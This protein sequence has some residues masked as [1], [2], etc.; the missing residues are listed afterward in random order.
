M[1]PDNRQSPT[2]ECPTRR[3]AV[4]GVGSR[5]RSDDALG[6]AI[7]ERV[8]SLSLPGVL[9]V[10]GETAPENVTG[11]IR[12][13]VPTHVLFV[14]AA[15]LGEAP[16]TARLFESREIGGVTSSTHSLPLHV[17]ADYLTQEIGC[18]VLFLGVQPRSV[19]FGGEVSRDVA[20][21]IEGT[22]A[23]LRDVLS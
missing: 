10:L 22:V 12:R 8:A 20:A 21:A 16:G 14:D 23:A 11:E 17:I 13:F 19:A 15:D 1:R 6:L 4:V 3:V 5:L 2:L 18:R 9:V 7:A